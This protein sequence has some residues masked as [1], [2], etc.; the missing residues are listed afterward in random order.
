[1]KHLVGIRSL[2]SPSPRLEKTFFSLGLSLLDL[3]SLRVLVPAKLGRERSSELAVH[4]LQVTLAS[5][6]AFR[7]EANES[8]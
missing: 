6:T 7:Y 5:C 8:G 2:L 4:F 1:M 3:L